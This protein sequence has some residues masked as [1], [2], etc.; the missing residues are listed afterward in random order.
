MQGSI[1]EGENM[2]NGKSIATHT[3]SAFSLITCASMF[4]LL[5]AVNLQAGQRADLTQSIPPEIQ[6]PPEAELFLVGHG[7]G[8]QNYVCVPSGAGVAFTLFTPQATLFDDDL[9]QITTHFF[10]PNPEE[11]NTIRATWEHSRDTSMVWGAVTHQQVVREDSIAWLRVDVKGA[12]SGPTGGNKLTPTKFI[13]RINTVGGLAPATECRGAKDIGN[14]A[15]VPY[16]ADY[17]FYKSETESQ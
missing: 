14:K 5:T 8:T 1:D 4:A 3:I 16:S 13:Q 11:N 9:Q 6:V 15:F 17:L 7:F 2:Q 12:A 10:S